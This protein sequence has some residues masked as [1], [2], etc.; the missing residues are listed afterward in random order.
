M[1]K[2]NTC[3]SDFSLK[4][5]QPRYWLTWLGLFLFFFISLF[6]TSARHWL[7]KKLGSLIY[8]KNKKRKHVT[9]TNLRLCFPELNQQQ[10]EMLTEEHLQWYGCALF[11]YSFFF[12]SSKKRLYRNMYIEGKEHIDQALEQGS[13]IIILLGHSVFLE[14][15]PVMLG[16]YFNTYGSYKPLSNPLIDWMIARSRCKHVKF[17][18]S[19][20]EG[21]MR[22][23]RE[24]RN[25]QI[26]IFLPDEDHGKEHSSFANF[27]GLAKSTLNTPAR[28]ARLAKA[29]SFPA[30]AFYDQGLKKYKI[31]IGPS[32]ENYPTKD[33]EKNTAIMNQG[34]ELLIQQYPAQYM[35]LMKLF[36]TL[37]DSNKNRY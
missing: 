13:N 15:V 8:K 27:F 18:V 23:V 9:S 17:V 35:W 37:P 24:L 25:Q 5:F 26:L 36:K 31:I 4:F 1:N 30:M 33:H 10:R 11:D 14:F 32:L 29:E 12:F 19:R 16:Q 6:P 21:M 2:N 3:G 22:L 20:E 28:I 34:F 7:G